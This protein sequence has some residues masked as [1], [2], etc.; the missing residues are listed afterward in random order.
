MCLFQVSSSDKDNLSTRIEL[1]ALLGS[2]NTKEIL[3]Y[4]CKQRKVQYKDFDLSISVPTLST[5]LAKLLKFDLIEHCI[6]KEPK[7]REWYEI[8][9]RGKKVLKIMEDMIRQAEE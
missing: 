7:R 9:G 1:L 6:A 2:K 5:R 4:L 3:R 8:T